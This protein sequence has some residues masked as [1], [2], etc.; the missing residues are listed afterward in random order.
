MPVCICG[1][2]TQQ[3]HCTV[4][5]SFIDSFTAKIV[6][7]WKETR[8]PPTAFQIPKTMTNWRIRTMKTR[9]VWKWMRD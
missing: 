8:V 2:I 6:L 9:L 3:L 7:L 4:I 1:G 5:V